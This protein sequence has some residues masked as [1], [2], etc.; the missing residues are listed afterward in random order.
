MIST[1]RLLDRL[2]KPLDTPLSE[3]NVEEDLILLTRLDRAACA[4]PGLESK[5]NNAFDLILTPPSATPQEAFAYQRSLV[6]FLLD[7]DGSPDDLLL[8]EDDPKAYEEFLCND[9]DSDP[10]GLRYMLLDDP[11]VRRLGSRLC[12]ATE[13]IEDPRARAQSYRL[14]GE[15][16]R[17]GSRTA[18]K[19]QTQWVDAIDQIEPLSQ[20][21]EYLFDTAKEHEFDDPVHYLVAKKCVAAIAEEEDCDCELSVTQNLCFEAPLHTPLQDLLLDHWKQLV[22]Y[23][24]PDKD[25]R[26]DYLYDLLKYTKHKERG[27]DALCTDEN[28][29]DQEDVF[30][31]PVLESTQSRYPIYQMAL[32]I[33]FEDAALNTDPMTRANHYAALS[34]LSWEGDPLTHLIVDAWRGAVL[35]IVDNPDDLS[36][37]DYL[38]AIA[39]DF[40]E[41]TPLGEEALYVK[42]LIEER[43][44]ARLSRF[45][46]KELSKQ[47]GSALSLSHLNF[48]QK[49]LPPHVPSKDLSKNDASSDISDGL[50]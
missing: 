16:S 32:G 37:R 41:E 48:P 30:D 24:Y 14:I 12:K 17:F 46:R 39:E 42:D 50:K 1:K 18:I 8:S 27:T 25:D 29:L 11:L 15:I 7:V 2:K 26:E 33:L 31:S 19:S 45:Q 22:P 40:S 49:M 4:A 43:Y 35:D 21:V 34:K 3:R 36:Y 23:V 38:K 20:R 6:N 47:L 28:L 44:E 5:I 10:E 9:K 13:K